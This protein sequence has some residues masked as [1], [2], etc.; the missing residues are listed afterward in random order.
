MCP[1]G[2]GKRG[3]PKEESAGSL[4]RK[5]GKQ[6]IIVDENRS[7]DQEMASTGQITLDYQAIED[8]MITDMFDPTKPTFYPLIQPLKPLFSRLNFLTQYDEKG[9]RGFK[10]AVNVA[11]SQLKNHTLSA[12]DYL[13]LENLRIY[14]HNRAYD[15]FMG[16]KIRVLATRE[17]HIT[18]NDSSVAE[19][20]KSKIFGIFPR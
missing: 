19:P 3:E 18:V 10:I 6:D 12:K 13:L 17:K 2:L 8:E 9:L 4:I 5:Q 20:P 7:V 1:F 14:L 15:S 11:I 16:F